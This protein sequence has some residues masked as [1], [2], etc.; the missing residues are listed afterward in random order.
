[1]KT[2]DINI[3][4]ARITNIALQ[5]SETGEIDLIASAALLCGNKKLASFSIRTDYSFGNDVKVPF[6]VDITEPAAKITK[7]IETILVRELNKYLKQLPESTVEG[8]VV[9]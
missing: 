5:F 3:N 6:P 4:H 8:G 9:E 1:M 7:T 2:I